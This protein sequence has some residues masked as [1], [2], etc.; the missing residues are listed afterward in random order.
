M[1]SVI[2]KRFTSV[3]ALGL[4]AT[5][6][7]AS[8][9]AA[10]DVADGAQGAVEGAADVAG[11]VAGGAVDAAGDVAGG[12]VDVAGDVAGGAADAAGGAVDAVAGA[13]GDA[14]SGAAGGL[15]ALKDGVTG[16]T[17]SITS[18]VDS[19]KSGDF[20]A[21]KESF[22]GVE[23][24]WGNLKGVIPGDTAGIEEKIAEVSTGLA[25]DAPDADSVLS[26]LGGLKDLVGGLAGN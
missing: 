25:S 13:A 2:M 7:L 10:K 1:R 17:G 8:C 3:F 16:M 14:A 5:L 18:T 9:N 12:A 19:V 4:A 15:V 20:A 22:S 21:A 24:A 26:S 11:D 6:G 23:T